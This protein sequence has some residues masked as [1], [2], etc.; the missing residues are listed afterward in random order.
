MTEQ[1]KKQLGLEIKHIFDSGANAVR[2]F[3]TMVR[4]IDN[5]NL[6][7]NHGGIGDVRHF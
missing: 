3:E 6:I 7:K 1:D 4:F 2:V 5:R